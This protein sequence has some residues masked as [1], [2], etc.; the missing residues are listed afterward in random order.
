MS[1][2]VWLKVEKA[3]P[4]NG[5]GIFVRQDGQTKEI[6]RQEWDEKFP[7]REPVVMEYG[8]TNCVYSANITHNLND[9]ADAAG[10]YEALW[11]PEQNDMNIAADLITVLEVGLTKLKK[12]PNEFKKYNP[13]NGWGD[14]DGLVQF[15]KNYL[16]ACKLHPLATVHVSR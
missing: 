9:M 11:R 5:S 12:E 15:V 16:A 6:S 14:Y 10:I 3:Q 7:D 13:K 2:D 1:L 4:R 8:E